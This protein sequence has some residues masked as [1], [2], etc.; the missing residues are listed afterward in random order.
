[1][2]STSPDQAFLGGLRRGEMASDH[3]TILSNALLRDGT[4]SYRAKGVFGNMASHREG[5]TITEEF[6]ASMGTEGISAIRVALQ[7]LRAA[8]YIYR[9]ERMRYPKGTVNRKGKD[10]SGALG[11]YQWYVTDKP[12]EIAAILTQYTTE[13][14]RQAPPSDQ[15]ETTD[16]PELGGAP[17]PDPEEPDPEPAHAAQG[18]D[19]PADAV[20]S[21]AQ[22]SSEV[23]AQEQ[24][25]LDTR[26]IGLAARRG[27]HGAQ[28]KALARRSDRISAEL[29]SRGIAP[30]VPDPQELT[31]AEAAPREQRVR[32][33]R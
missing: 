14:A 4:I 23:L 9:G 19:S 33:R 10:I 32:H 28:Y 2:S 7:E 27:S 20:D 15:P 25:D 31:I 5:F 16:Q 1:M 17:E 26:L 22:V 18:I 3:F 6:L 13:Q 30:V 29:R 24:R 8:G 21:L 11:A 12:E